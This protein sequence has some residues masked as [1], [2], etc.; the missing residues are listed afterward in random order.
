MDIFTEK[1]IEAMIDQ[2]ANEMGIGSVDDCYA[3]MRFRDN[4]LEMKDGN[5]SEILRQLNYVPKK[6]DPSKCAI[7]AKCR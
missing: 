1:M 5:N 4:L 7:C 2:V 3:L 6:F